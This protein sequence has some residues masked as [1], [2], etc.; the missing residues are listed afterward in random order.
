MAGE[1]L[2]LADYSIFS[3]ILVLNF[4]IPIE[5]EKWPRL[6]DYLKRFESNPNYELNM[7]GARKQVDLIDKCMEK[8]KN[9]HINS[10]EL[11]YPKPI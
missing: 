9:Y 8:A 10:F 4:L 6:A 3:T 11:I 7:E 5:A 1:K 2:T